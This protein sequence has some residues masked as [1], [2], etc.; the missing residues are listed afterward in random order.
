MNN[1]SAIRCRVVFYV[2]IILTVACLVTAICFV[3]SYELVGY[4]LFGATGGLILTQLLLAAL[5][6][7]LKRKSKVNGFAQWLLSLEV[8]LV[9]VILVTIS[10]IMFAL[11]IVDTIQQKNLSQK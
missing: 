5:V 9:V 4:V 11:W 10:P 3:G 7:V 6:T 2:G 8:L 1:K